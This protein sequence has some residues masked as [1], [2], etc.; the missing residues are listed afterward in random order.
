M[1]DHGD[2][3]VTH[4]DEL[5]GEG[6]AERRAHDV[7][8]VDAMHRICGRATTRV[9]L[10]GGE[11]PSL[12][13]RTN[14]GGVV[15]ALVEP[16]LVGERDAGDARNLSDGMGHLRRGHAV[17]GLDHDVAGDALDVRDGERLQCA[18]QV[19]HELVLEGRAVLALEANLVVV[20][21]AESLGHGLLDARVLA[22]D[23][24]VEVVLDKTEGAV[25]D[26]AHGDGDRVLA[27]GD[28]GDVVEVLDG[29]HAKVLAT[30]HV[31]D[32]AGALGRN[33]AEQERVVLGPLEQGVDLGLNH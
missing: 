29:R 10:E 23:G 26:L 8:H 31:V 11:V 19:S 33:G 32:V 12:A 17:L 16:A 3:R 15:L 9:H 7:V 6:L 5:V 27:G 2:V 18:V 1:D 4:L 22:A 13:Q 24:L 28:G 20:D 25:S 21:Q 30:Q 14:G